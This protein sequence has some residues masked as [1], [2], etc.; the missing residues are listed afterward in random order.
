MHIEIETLISWQ[1]LHEKT[2][3]AYQIFKLNINE[4]D[5][6]GFSVIDFIVQ[7]YA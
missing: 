7:R 1:I 5:E 4:S 6:H 2:Y 3:P